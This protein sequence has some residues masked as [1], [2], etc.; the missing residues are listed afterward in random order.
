MGLSS[1]VSFETILGLV[2]VRVLEAAEFC[3]GREEEI[4]PA[5]WGRPKYPSFVIALF[6]FLF[7][8]YVF[9]PYSLYTFS[10]FAYSF[11]FITYCSS[12]AFI[13]ALNVYIIL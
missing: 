3:G 4:F 2:E 5:L 13:T 12:F 9:M 11:F 7:D 6:S 8:D 10:F 1:W